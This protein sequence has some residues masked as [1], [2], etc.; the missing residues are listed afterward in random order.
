MAQGCRGGKAAAVR[1]LLRRLRIGASRAERPLRGSSA[2]AGQSVERV[3]G[4]RGMRR[5]PKL[6]AGARGGAHRRDPRHRHEL[7]SDEWRAA[8]TALSAE[9]K[10]DL[11]AVARRGRLLAAGVRHRLRVHQR[12]DPRYR[13][14]DDR[15]P[16][17]RRRAEGTAIPAGEHWKL[18]CA[19][20]SASAW[21]R[22]AARSAMAGISNSRPEMSWRKISSPR[23]HRTGRS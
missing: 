20:T 9:R 6:G 7:D 19:P 10:T 2:A 15:H 22:P 5:R 1:Q 13:W 11:R 8:V 17:G 14:T 4:A 12:R 16:P 23:R 21:P 18:G 3:C